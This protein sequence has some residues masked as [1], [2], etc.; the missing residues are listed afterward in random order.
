MTAKPDLREYVRKG[1]QNPTKIPPF[2]LGRLFP[3]SRWAPELRPG[4]HFTK[5]VEG[6]FAGGSPTRPE[7]CARLY[8]ETTQLEELLGD[9]RYDRSLEF[10]CGFGRLTGWIAD[11]ADENVAIDPDVEVLGE[12]ER[13]YPHVEFV[14]AIG[15]RL[16]FDDESFDLAVSWMV[17]TH[18]PPSRFAR[19]IDEL[20]R[21]VTPTG[22]ILLCERTRGEHRP[23]TRPQPRATYEE[24]F[25]PYE[26]Q[27]CE[28]R[29]TEPTWDHSDN[30]DVMRF[31]R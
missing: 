30:I 2:L 24:H 7:L 14:P 11:Y 28:T 29:R 5:F 16:P 27:Q 12:A 17:L 21:V 3:R 22:T 8:Y 10:G 1:V 15:N 25:A 6:G 26:L 13:N 19:T 18:V 20:K 4:T 9:R 23:G 31:E